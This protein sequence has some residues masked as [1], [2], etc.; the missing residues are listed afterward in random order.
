MESHLSCQIQLPAPMT[1]KRGEIFHFPH[2][3]VLF[4]YNSICAFLSSSLFF[5]PCCFISF[6]FLPSSHWVWLKVTRSL[7]HFRRGKK[8]KDGE[9]QNR[10]VG[11]QAAWLSTVL[12]THHFLPRTWLGEVWKDAWGYS[13]SLP[14]NTQWPPQTRR[15]HFPALTPTYHGERPQPEMSPDFNCKH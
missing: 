1:S 9:L 5:S 13:L 15:S 11:S 12:C 8:I 4:F 10:R 3:S 7:A 14:C 6:P 2:S